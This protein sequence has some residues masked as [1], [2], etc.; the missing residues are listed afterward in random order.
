MQKHGEM[1]ESSCDGKKEQTTPRR[2]HSGREPPLGFKQRNA[3]RGG[4][5]YGISPGGYRWARNALNLALLKRLSMAA[6]KI[7]QNDLELKSLLIFMSGMSTGQTSSF[8]ISEVRYSG[9]K[10]RIERSASEW[11][12]G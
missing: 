4:Y 9:S 7:I 11:S 10:G 8:D 2:L 3:K 12:E 6:P 5:A 1:S